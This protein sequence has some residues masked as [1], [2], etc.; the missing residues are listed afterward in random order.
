MLRIGLP[1]LSLVALTACD[2]V[3]LIEK[4]G[5]VDE[6]EIS[7]AT[8]PKRGCVYDQAPLRVLPEPVVIPTRA[9]KFF[10]TATSLTFVDSRGREWVAPRRTLTDGASIPPIFVSIVG[11]PTSPE[12]INAAA[13]HDA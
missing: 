12:F 11:D 6:P 5:T 4:A 3:A 2:P 1:A 8:R 9:Y 13:V 10:P 7:C